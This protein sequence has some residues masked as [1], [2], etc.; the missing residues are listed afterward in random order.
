MLGGRVKTLH[1]AVHGGKAFR[2]AFFSSIGILARDIPSDLKDLVEQNIDKIDVVVCNLYP[3]KE[4][5]AK[6]GVTIEEAIEE[7]DIG[8]FF[9]KIS[10][11]YILGGVTLLRAAAKNHSRVTILSDP[12]DYNQFLASLGNLD[13]SFLQFRQALALKAFSHTADY[14]EA[15]S[16]YF[17][18]LYGPSLNSQM[19]LRYGANPHQ[20]PAQVFVKE[21]SLPIKGTFG[22]DFYLLLSS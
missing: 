7:I 22:S 10:L 21:G 17:R 1:P 14:D 11:I 4:T 19:T 13:A 8:T 15:I 5:I 12:S 20:K 9:L 18:K 6:S 16:D 2:R 3:F